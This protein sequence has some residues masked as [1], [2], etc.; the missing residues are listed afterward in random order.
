MIFAACSVLGFWAFG[1]EWPVYEWEGVIESP[2]GKFSLVVLRE[3]VA[4]FADFSYHV[5]CFRGKQ[6]RRTQ[7]EPILPFQTWLWRGSRVYSG[8]QYYGA[9]WIGLR[10]ID[11]QLSGANQSGQ[12]IPKSYLCETERVVVSR[13]Y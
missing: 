5:Y 2:D 12:D 11:I 3:D 9:S 4:A 6:E 13:K 1:V 8:D 10:A 7:H